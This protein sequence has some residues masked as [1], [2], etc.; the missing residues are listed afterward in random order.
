MPSAATIPFAPPPKPQP[1]SV[2][3]L[4]KLDQVAELLGVSR[5]TAERLVASR[6]LA[7]VRLGSRVRIDPRDLRAFIDRQKSGQ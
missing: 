3:P 6:E 2:E 7:S 1:P 4:L 5:R